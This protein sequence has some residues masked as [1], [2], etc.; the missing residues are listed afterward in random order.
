MVKGI[1][2]EPEV[3]IFPNTYISD[4]S[5]LTIT[6]KNNSHQNHKLSFRTYKTKSEEQALKEDLDIYDPLARAKFNKSYAFESDTFYIE[7][8]E[9]EVWSGTSQ[10]FFITYAPNIA[11]RHDTTVYVQVDEEDE[12]LELKLIALGLPPVAQLS[13]PAINIGNIFLD[14]IC[15]YEVYLENCGNVPVDFIL[16]KHPTGNLGFKFN[17]ETGQVL[18]GS[19]IPIRITFIA[20]AVGSFH[21]LFTYKIRGATNKFPQIALTGKVIG[22]S[23]EVSMHQLDFGSVG[24][25]FMHTQTFILENTSEIPFDFTFRLSANS[26]FEHRE[27]RI[28]PE[29]GTIGKFQK[30]E[31]SI[32]FIPFAIQEY[33]LTLLMDVARYGLALLEIPIRAKSVCPSIKLIPDVVDY[34]TAF[35]GYKYENKIT[36]KN[37][38]PYPAKFE[39]ISGQD[40][41]RNDI[42]IACDKLS[43]I[44]PA[45]SSTEVII[46]STCR[47][48]GPLQKSCLFSIFGSDEPPLMLN[49]TANCVGPN[50]SFSTSSINFGNLQVLKETKQIIEVKNN[51]LIDANFRTSLDS[52]TGG[53][54][55]SPSSGVIKPNETLQLD[56]IA[57]LN[58][59]LQFQGTIKFGI[60]YLNSS[61]IALKA[62]GVGSPIIPDIDQKTIDFGTVLTQQPSSKVFNITN[63]SHRPAEI[64]WSV[65]KPKILKDLPNDFSFVVEPEQ[66]F[67]NPQQSCEVKMTIQCSNPISFT[68]NTTCNAM[69]GRSR[70]EAFQPLIKGTFISPSIQ[71]E[72]SSLDYQ[73]LLPYDKEKGDDRSL[74]S[75]PSDILQPIPKALTLSNMSKLPI[76]MTCLMP[77]HFFIENFENLFSKEG[78]EESVLKINPGEKKDLTVV[79]DPSFKEEFVTEEY[80]RKIVFS[81]LNNPQSISLP[82]HVNVEFPNIKITPSDEI[83]F[84]ILMMDTEKTVKVTVQNIVSIPV[85]FTWKMVSD[86]LDSARVFDVF[87]LDSCLEPGQSVDIYFSFYALNDENELRTIEYFAEAVCSVMNGPDYRLKLK[88]SSAPIQYNVA[89][90][91][92]DFTGKSFTEE[93]ND[94]IV[95]TNNSAVEIQFEVKL[96]RHSKFKQLKIEPMNGIVSANDFVELNLSILPS[97]PNFV[98]ESFY[99][100]ISGFDDVQINVRVDSSFAQGKLSLQRCEDDP[101]VNN[102]LTNPTPIKSVKSQGKVKNQR[103][104]TAQSIQV[105]RSENIADKM[106]QLGEDKLLKEEQKVLMDIMKGKSIYVHSAHYKIDFGDLVMGENREIEFN[107]TNI[108]TFSY[109]VNV[110]SS[111]LKRSG[112][113]IEPIA[114]KGISPNTDVSF[115]VNFMTENRKLNEIG[116][117]SYDVPFVFSDNHS[118]LVT[119]RANLIHPSLTFSE[120]SFDFGQVIIGQMKTMTLQLQNMN[121]VA[122]EFT[123]GDVVFNKSS[124]GNVFVV[125]PLHGVLPPSSFMNITITFSPTSEKNYN[126]K[127]PVNLRYSPEPIEI[128]LKGIGIQYKL[129][130][131]PPNYTFPLTQLFKEPLSTIIKIRNPTNY[132]IEFYSSQFDQKLQELIEQQQKTDPR[133]DGEMPFVTYTP[134]A[135]TPAAASKFGICIILSGIQRSGKTSVANHLSKELNLPIIDLKKVWQG[136]NQE[137]YVSKLYGVLCETQNRNGFIIDN[138]NISDT[139]NENEQFIQQMLKNKNALDEISK[140]LMYNGQHQTPSTYEECLGYLLQSL[141]GQYVFHISLTLSKEELQIRLEKQKQNENLTK[142]SNEMKE[143]EYLNK[144]TTEEYLNMPEEQR[145]EID[146]KRHFYRQK[147]LDKIIETSRSEREEDENHK[148]SSKK[149][150]N[151][152]KNSK[153]N[154]KAVNLD[155]LQQEMLVYQFSLSSMITKLE[156][157][158]DRYKTIDPSELCLIDSSNAVLV[159]KNSIVINGGLQFND[160]I[161]QINAFLPPVNIIKEAAFKRMIPEPYMTNENMDEEIQMAKKIPRHFY[162]QNPEDESNKSTPHWFLDSGQ[163]MELNVKFD[164]QPIGNISEELTFVICRCAASPYAIKLKGSAS[165]P[166]FER[167]IKTIFQPQTKKGEPGYS[168]ELSCFTF[169]NRLICKEKPPK[170]PFQYKEQM[171]IKNTTLFPLEVSPMVVESQNKQF[172]GFEPALLT[173]QP[174]QKGDINCLFHPTTNGQSF[175]LCALFVKDNPDPFYFTVSGETSSPQ[176]DLISQQNIDY[177][178][179]LSNSTSVKKVDLKNTG[180]V[181]AT[182]RL[183]GQQNFQGLLTFSQSEGQILPGKTISIQLKFSHPKPVVLKKPLQIEI[184]DL[185]HTKVFMTH[186]LNISGEVFDVNCDVVFPKGMNDSFDFGL[187]KC[188]QSKNI[189][190]QVRNRGKYPIEY[191]FSANDNTVNINNPDN[192]VN[193]GDK[194]NLQNVTFTFSSNSTVKI[195]GNKTVSL[196]IVDTQTK[197]VTANLTYPIN[198]E[199]FFSTYETDIP[200]KI[201]FGETQV[202][203]SYKKEFTIKNTGPFPIEYNFTVKE[204]KNTDSQPIETN[205]KSDGKTKNDKKAE[206]SKEK[207]EPSKNKKNEK[208]LFAGPFQI[209]PGS[210]TIQPNQTQTVSFEIFATDQG[211]YSSIVQLNVPGTQSSSSTLTMRLFANVSMPGILTESDKV[212]KEIPIAARVDVQSNTTSDASCFLEDENILHFA[213]ICQGQK[214]KITLNYINVTP[215]EITVDTTIKS[216]TKSK[217]PLPF[218]VSEKTSV[219]K[220]NSTQKIDIIYSPTAI[221]QTTCQFEAVVRGGINP[222]TKCLRFG[223]E[224]SSTLPSITVQTALEKGKNNG[225][226]CNMGKTLVGQTKQKAVSIINDK[227][228][229]AKISFSYKPNPDFLVQNAELNKEITLEPGRTFTF[230]VVHQPQK[231]RKSSLD[232]T[233]NLPENN[234]SNQ[235]FSFSGEGFSDDIIFDGLTEENELNMPSVVVG[236]STNYTFTM[237]NVITSDVR[238]VWNGPPEL[239]FSPKVGHIRSGQIKDIT[240][241]FFSEKPCKLSGVKTTCSITKIVLENPDDDWDDTQKIVSF[242][243]KS[244]LSQN[245]NSPRRKTKPETTKNDNEVV[246]ISQVRAEPPYRAITGAS[247]RGSSSRDFLIKVFVSADVIKYQIDTNEVNFAPTMMYQ[248]RTADVNVT[249]TSQIRLEYEWK[250]E[251]FKSL[252]TDYS[253]TRPSPF[254]IEPM[255]GIIEAGE[256][257]TFKVHFSPMEVDDFTSVFRMIIPY[258][259]SSE[260]PVLNL[261]AFSRRPLCHFN[262]PP[263]D[264]LTRRHPDFANQAL[265]DST[266]VIEILSKGRG[267]D[268]KTSFRF[269]VI[270]PTSS[271]YECKWSLITDSSGGAITCDIPKALISSGKHYYFSFTFT[272][273]TGK[274]VESLWEFSIP[275]HGIKAYFLVVGRNSR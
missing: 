188:G 275:Q 159:H 220:P 194:N 182:W 157:A 91:D 113:K 54:S 251:D 207:N 117:V 18:V 204:I 56:V 86:N 99:V 131:D 32:E 25:G 4:V 2:F 72:P 211:K 153:K 174:D 247:S 266:S 84:G 231:V 253:I 259:T 78:D 24:Y 264:Y 76:E 230:T 120:K 250:E 158:G 47:K 65:Q 29:Q 162:I 265:P 22:P 30:Q 49:F 15:E 69:V 48:I 109:S 94:K 71:I 73:V 114:L 144:M 192:T 97:A 210:A 172:F 87:P 274:T 180:K 37:D 218:D 111:A 12:R 234:K 149:E 42:E 173:L 116:E 108:S 271:P 197:S 154:A 189:Q 19:K 63:K 267:K 245:D 41:H 256:V 262:I 17:P 123:F 9:L 6:V 51:S 101:S 122:C 196:K 146:E 242:V 135:K 147:I 106:Q 130:F 43:G 260:P 16:E 241:K 233:I 255:T 145:N 228:I 93:L 124:K 13:N 222:Q 66:T 224:G 85:N 226:S 59:I 105:Y 77:S 184:L 132:S 1:V 164:P 125:T 203:T 53:F 236:R 151:K 155:P 103:S 195:T 270:N 61:N 5:K 126:A 7:P 79:F 64:R 198:A 217:A 95:L 31:I 27:F 246:K 202:T 214:S 138:L 212:F 181:A 213:Q 163:E 235:S 128:Q 127:F 70:I 215:I 21:E 238:F 10:Q 257:K 45:L 227:L 104:G 57:F 209:S 44:I 92:F 140:N 68:L 96:P 206:K 178:R 165:F 83:N 136:V 23:F 268:A 100:Q 3:V 261:T 33:N 208:T 46:F 156:S 229:P 143:I 40:N 121:S 186:N 200:A 187:L 148:K 38:F 223:I 58:D 205:T 150:E 112:F 102:L 169:G 177:E 36:L 35:I 201:Q 90:T 134:K 171:T 219:I 67:L 258:L 141:D 115:R 221:E 193:P 185:D 191:H 254:S 269:E 119:I 199:S 240:V 175:A 20:S 190:V 88:G 248:I 133:E 118:V 225:Y 110:D 152:D 50:V 82:L 166:D 89:P 62:Q 98:R 167:D 239:V 249:N 216:N 161:N 179:I 39:F 52:P 139:K 107:L 176:I 237:R 129:E 60:D 170:G 232:L 8:L 252:K 273:K 160:V 142:E 34:Q 11:I 81:Y 80:T 28:D 168:N 137:D 272:P 26:T 183:K 75:P 263:C 14:S 244:E 243:P 74:V 55:V